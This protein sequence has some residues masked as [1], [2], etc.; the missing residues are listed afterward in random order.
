MTVAQ[1]THPRTVWDYK[2]ASRNRWRVTLWDTGETRPSP[3][4][5]TETDG[6]VDHVWRYEV[7]REEGGEYVTV[8]IGTHTGQ[9]DLRP[10]LPELLHEFGSYVLAV[11][12][13]AA[14]HAQIVTGEAES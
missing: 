2:D 1:Y 14:L 10:E 11:C 4:S 7:E 12:I 9:Y 5:E 3:G 8:Y 6:S 13:D